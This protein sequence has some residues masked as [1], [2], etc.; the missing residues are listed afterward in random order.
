MTLERQRSRSAL[1]ISLLF[2]LSVH[3]LSQPVNHEW[4]TV[5]ANLHESRDL[6]VIHLD[7]KQEKPESLFCGST[8]T[9]RVGDN[10]A[11]SMFLVETCRQ[12]TLTSR[13]D[14]NV[15]GSTFLL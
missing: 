15:A 1:S 13:V 14:D 3:F 10:V 4:L 6:Y 11:G 12:H 2:T 7:Q 9:S 8:L 5:R